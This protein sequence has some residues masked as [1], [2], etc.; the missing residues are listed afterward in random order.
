MENPAAFS[1]VPIQWYE[2]SDLMYADIYNYLI[3][4]PSLYTHEQLKSYKSLDAYNQFV[5]G[6]VSEI[7][8][9]V[10]NANKTK[11]YLL[12][13][14]VKHSQS[15]SLP[16]LK[17]WVVIN[18]AGVVLCA[19]CSC[20]AGCGEACSHI[21]SL[22]FTVEAN[23]QMKQQF[24]CTSLP[25][26]WLPSSFRSVSFSE[27]RKI[28]FSTPQHKRMQCQGSSITEG[29]PVRKMKKVSVPKA[30][31]SELD[32]F[33][34]DLSKAK[35]KPVLLSLM[36]KYSDSYIPET[37][38]GVLPKPLTDLHDPMAMKMNY[39]DLLDRCESIYQSVSFTFSQAVLVEER[40]RTQAKCKRWFELR[41]GRITASKLHQAIHTSH[42]QPSV[43]LVKSICYPE[44]RKFLSA[45]CQYGC[46]H[47][48]I[49]RQAYVEKL[50]MDHE[51]FMVIQC[52]LILDPEF[53]FMGATPDGLVNCKCC[54][55][56]VLEI[57]CPF[58]CKNKDVAETASENP[59]FFL[60]DDNGQVTLKKDHAYFFQVQLQMKLCQV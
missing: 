3:L 41:A 4:T 59:S 56:G 29:E 50:R 55:T 42:L 15:L 14:L 45:A 34:S 38:A 23:T 2:W 18:Q 26:S 10:N 28:D 52:S 20:M 37:E 21:A 39:S 1:G 31:D 7:I 54:D 43:S 11:I 35:G 47:E 9:T 32:I 60:N 46:K 44:Q 57:K 27:I 51:N 5:N 19:H 24:S 8:V 40:T 22:L 53:P 30:T 12:T 48:D 16:P 25:C 49:A 13:A 17:P 33:Y 6:W 36:P 58:S